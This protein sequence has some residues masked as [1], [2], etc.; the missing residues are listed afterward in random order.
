MRFTLSSLELE[1]ALGATLDEGRVPDLSEAVEALR[2]GGGVGK[3]GLGER[4]E[5]LVQE[6]LALLKGEAG[7]V[8][9]EVEGREGDA[10]VDHRRGGVGE[11]AA[12]L[13][14]IGDD[15][16]LVS[17]DLA[18][19]VEVLAS[20][21]EEG[22]DILALGRGGHLAGAG[23]GGLEEL[24]AEALVA[25]RRGGEAVA[26]GGSSEDSRALL[27]RKRGDGE[28]DDAG[29]AIL[30][31]DVA[32]RDGAGEALGGEEGGGDGGEFNVCGVDLEDGLGGDGD[33]LGPAAVDRAD[34]HGVASLD[35]L[36]GA[37]GDDLS[38]TLGAAN[39]EAARDGLSLAEGGTVDDGGVGAVEGGLK[40]LDDD[41]VG[42]GRELDLVE[43]EDA[44]DGAA[45]GVGEGAGG[46]GHCCF[47]FRFFYLPICGCASLSLSLVLVLV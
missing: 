42:G 41:G 17:D 44:V 2:D 29:A 32:L 9:G 23:G 21:V 14:A 25:L 7:E 39:G 34:P 28:G 26:G 40:G 20:A 36:G 33:L 43:L 10:S 5:G 30:N 27:L 13:R 6:R 1:D 16:A 18:E 47:F 12:G 38:D 31:N 19:L 15:G 24:R 37:G 45:A 4:L 3:L 8:G 22:A 35:G 46:N 11:G